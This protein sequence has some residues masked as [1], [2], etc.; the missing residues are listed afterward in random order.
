MDLAV[1]KFLENIF[2]PKKQASAGGTGSQHD[3]Q[4]ATAALLVELAGSDDQFT[5]EEKEAITRNLQAYFELTEAEVEEIIAAGKEQLEH[6]LDLYYFAQQ[7]N[8]RFTR[9]QKIAVIEMVWRVIYSDNHLS[10]LE[11]HLAHRFARLLRL[12]HSELIAAKLRVKDE[13]EST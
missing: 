5:P 3:I 8:R 13:R 4:V 11:D 2:G 10:G 6:R 9:A 1:K 12:D 7:I